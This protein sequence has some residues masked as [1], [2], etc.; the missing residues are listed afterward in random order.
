VGRATRQFVLFLLLGVLA[1]SAM[2]VPRAADSEPSTRES[3]DDLVIKF[4]SDI[5]AAYGALKTGEIDM[6]CSELPKELYEDAIEDQNIVLAPVSDYDFYEFD[7]NNN[8]SIDDYPGIRSPTSYQGFRQALAWLTDKDYII[9]TF[10]GDWLAE[11]IDQMIAAPL[12]GWANESMWYP[13][14][15]YEYD[16]AKAAEALEAAGF[17]QGTTLNPYF[18]PTFPGSAQ[19]IRTYPAGHETAGQDL[20]PVILCVRFD[21]MRRAQAGVLLMDNM[22]K[23]GIPVAL[24]APTKA[25]IYDRVFGAMN[26]HIYT[27]GWSVGR[28]PPVML[29]GLFHSTNWYPYGSNYVTGNGTYPALDALL[30]AGRYPAS[31]GEAVG[32]TKLAAGYMTE[33]CITIPLYSSRS[34]WAYSKDL[35]SV[36]NMEG[37]GPD[38]SYTYLNAYKLDGTA[39]RCGLIDAP[40]FMNLLYTAWIE[41]FQCLN[42][43][44]T[45]GDI[46][47]SPYNL[48]MDQ[49]GFVRDWETSTWDDSG[50]NKTKI[51]KW[52]KDNVHFAEPVTGSQK[53]NVNASHLFF[54]AWLMYQLGDTWWSPSFSDIHH[55]DLQGPYQIEICFNATSYWFTYDAVGP[56]L[57]MD[58]WAAQ[59]E[60]ITKHTEDFLD[61]TTPGPIDLLEGPVWIE[62]ATFNGAP[63]TLGTDYNIVQGE[64]YIYSTLGT[65]TLEVK[66][67]SPG[68]AMGYTPGNVAWQTIFEGAGMY[69]STDFTPGIGGSLMLKRN[70]Y[71][72][73]A[74]PALG[75][76]DYVWWFEA[77]PKPRSGYYQINIYD[78]ALAG[79]AFGSQGALIPSRNWFPGADVAPNSGAVDIYDLVTI[80]SNLGETF[81][82]P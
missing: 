51:V 80:V 74:P 40:T 30:D 29:W 5:D 47:H 18:D 45:Y 43:M 48:A 76:V 71:Y 8:Y 39:L 42:K 61:P 72:W 4:Y 37:A 67:W 19:Y 46:A 70:P 27:G 77:G 6:V 12:K 21:S 24:I 25:A 41:D 66:Y 78:L 68:D 73:I 34:F 3:D 56:I 65:G 32:Y 59:P 13:N 63:L 69:Y 75:E 31:Y 23:H 16:P 10:C 1:F 35:L 15:P 50:L 54:S 7:I 33:L 82:E 58:T 57:P 55:I 20:D 9:D 28:F 14:Y 79:G 62:Y 2:N 44:N 22:E 26:Y 64:F 52:L 53:A 60:L 36:V 81:G 38:N 49:A 17:V 11:R